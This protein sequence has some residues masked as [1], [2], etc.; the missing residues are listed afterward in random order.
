M[1]YPKSQLPAV[2]VQLLIQGYFVHSEPSPLIV[3]NIKSVEGL[4]VDWISKHL[5]YTDFYHGSLS[6]LR[7]DMPNETKVLISGTGKP[8]SVA[9]HPLKG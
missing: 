6:V 7:L 8:R 4:S 1:F 2:Y 3:K 9:V 5:Y